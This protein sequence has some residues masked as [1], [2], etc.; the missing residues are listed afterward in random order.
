M[1]KHQ[2][3]C[4]SN[5][6]GSSPVMETEGASILWAISVEKHKLRYTVV[7]SDGDAKTISRLNSEHPYGTDIN[8]VST[9]MSIL[10]ILWWISNLFTFMVITYLFT[11][12][13]LLLF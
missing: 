5:S 9:F 12:V 7:I 1:A 6:T 11:F 8:Q 10:F 3:S 2:D 13:V 4:N